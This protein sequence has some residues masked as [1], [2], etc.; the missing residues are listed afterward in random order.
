ML[1]IKPV[2]NA[3][4]ALHYYSAKD[5]YYLSDKDE[6]QQASAW[7]GKGAA[8]LSLS[9]EVLPETFL[10]LLEGKLPSGQQLGINTGEGKVRHRPGTDVTLSAPKSVS[11]LALV[12]GDRRLVEAHNAAVRETFKVIEALAAEARMTLNGETRFEK[13]KNLVVALFQHTTS[14]ELDPLLHDHGVIM[15][16]TERHDGQWRALAS[17]SKQD[18][19]QL[20]HGFREFLYQ[21]QHYLGLIYNSSLAKGVCELGFEIEIKDR[22]GNFEIKGVPEHYLK[23]TSKR[24]SQILE[25]LEEKG[26]SGAKAAEIAT[27]DTR[28]RKADID[29]AT[30]H[31]RWQEEARQCGVDF[32]A[33]IAESKVRGA[34]SITP[35]EGIAVSETAKE[36]IDAALAELS[37]F[38]TEIRHGDLVR[39][40]FMFA[41]AALHH[42]ELEEEITARFKSK[43]LLG[44]ENTAYTT[45]ALLKQEKDFVRHF[46]S[47]RGSAEAVHSEA[48]GLAGEVLSR[49]DRVQLIDVHGLTHEKTL[50]DSLVHAAEDAGLKTKVLHPGRVQT[51]RLKETLSRDTSSLWKW[52]KA[53]FKGELVQTVASFAADD[54]LKEGMVIVHDAQ[55]L[56]FE[57]L[58]RLEQ[59]LKQ[60]RS[61]LVLLNNTASTEGF[62]AGSPMNALKSAGFTLRESI[63]PLKQAVISVT[64]TL[65]THE[66]LA[67]AYSRLTGKEAEVTQIAALTSRDAA[68]ITD[69]IRTKLKGSGRLAE[70]GQAVKMLSARQLSSAQKKHLKFYEVG[71]R[72]TLNPFTREQQHYRL[73]AKEDLSLK[74][75]DCRG[76][77]QSLALDK[78]SDCLVT[79]A[80]TLELSVGDRLINHEAIRFGRAGAIA[81]GSR[82]TV[83]A[84]S[85]KGASLATAKGVFT[86]SF[87]AMKDL[88]LAYD[89]VRRPGQLN[90]SSRILLAAE[91]YQINKTVFAELSE[92]AADIHLFTPD[93]T[94]A[95]NALK[96]D[97]RRLT[98]TEVAEGVS[99]RVYRNSR[100][101][102]TVIQK[103]LT[104]LSDALA[105]PSAKES[106]VIAQTALSYATAKL[107]EREA[108]FDHKEL[109]MEAMVFAMGKTSLTDIE[110]AIAE[111]AA[112]GDL[113]HANTRWVVREAYLLEKKILSNNRE[114]QGAVQPIMAESSVSLPQALTQGQK[115]AV[116]LSL[117]TSDRFVTVQGLA[118]T[119]KTT[120]MREIKRLAEDNGFKVQGLA[121]MNTSKDELKRAGMDA[122][123]IASFLT[124]EAPYPE[125]CLFIV[126]EASMVGNEDYFNLQEKAKTL[127]AR[128]LFAGDRTQLQSPA[129]GIPHELTLETKTQDSARMDE[130]LR[131]SPNPVLKKAVVHASNREIEAS[132][133]TLATINPEKHIRRTSQENRPQESVVTVNCRTKKG[134]MDYNRIYRAI[135]EDY[136]T[137]LPEQQAET[138]VIAHAH[139]DRAA[140]NALIRDGLKA[141]GV[142]TGNEVMVKRLAARHL[143]QAEL[144]AGD[145]YKA[146]DIL[147]FNASY[148]IARR[149]DY[150]KVIA[151]DETR[152][153]LHCE[154]SQGLQ[155]S[156]N[157][158]LIAG[159]TRLSV[160]EEKKSVLAAGD[161]IRLRLT[162]KR[163]GHIANKDYTVASIAGN[164]AVLKHQEETLHLDLSKPK[165]S[166]WDY[167]YTATALGAQGSTATF[168]LALELAKRSQATTHRSHEIDITRPREQ[169]T[170]Y[171][172]DKEALIKRLATLKGDKTSAWLTY[173]AAHPSPAADEKES[174]RAHGN[175]SSP[176][177]RAEVNLR[178]KNKSPDNPLPDARAVNAALMARPDE[179][180]KAILGEP[181]AMNA[182]EM[183]YGGG[184]IVTLQGSK[185]GLWYDFNEGRGGLPLD[186]IMAS[187]QIDFKEA[188]KV[189]ADLAGLSA[190]DMPTTRIKREST[191][192]NSESIKKA[193]QLSAKSIWDGSIPIKGT[194]AEI[195]LKQYRGIERTEGLDLRF[196]PAKAKWLNYREDGLVEKKVNQIPALIIAAKNADS[197]LTGVQR[198]YLDKGTGG[199][200]RF[201]DNPKLSKGTIEGSAAILQHGTKGAAIFIAEGPETAASI[202]ASFPTATVMASLGLS[203]MKNLMPLLRTFH[204]QEVVVAADFDGDKSKTARITEEVVNE[205]RK[206]GINVR[207]VYPEP[208]KG[209]KKTDWNDVLIHKGMTAI[210]LALSGE[211]DKKGEEFDSRQTDSKALLHAFSLA[212]KQDVLL[213]KRLMEQIKKEGITIKSLDKNQHQQ[214]EK[215]V[216]KSSA[217]VNHSAI[218]NA[219][220]IKEMER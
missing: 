196:W 177:A 161:R 7:Y 140:I 102:A 197:Q 147:R 144:R 146:G 22:Y 95:F 38:S 124:H 26:L 25:R 199:K 12:G 149:G 44:R 47:T 104:A 175:V 194:L 73:V 39:T 31:Q 203:N 23:Q 94:L 98:I 33:L 113:M 85:E 84:L 187:R 214:D 179:T 178:L 5:N 182:R 70:E 71:D 109:L 151:I 81:P 15:N 69:L 188:L 141:Q 86:F 132:F 10:A 46:K 207:V 180:Y 112:Q 137:R 219:V 52:V 142:V 34:G 168:V 92:Y 76:E 119:G 32:E 185:K 189:G 170:L 171:T 184:L 183:R 202:A 59:S 205:W 162:D 150:F 60:G 129:A 54:S 152:N 40:A 80:H 78:A 156:I 55:K 62:H 167:A 181:K 41:R 126:D 11:T 87:E 61:R 93:K 186:A 100:H 191:R 116:T 135:A 27:L 131:Q 169:V 36:A 74:L 111:K 6:L 14:R 51:A 115:E 30:L 209:F 215:M 153:R 97:A 110:Q 212:N 108:A 121:P 19:S 128:L 45:A 63:T 77:T 117:T 155:F 136:L 120:M 83:S 210:Q 213:Q 145:S 75:I 17:R 90:T 88:S 154:D 166:H 122:S 200:N 164:Q 158:A 208:L 3:S 68:S 103:D 143:T 49:Y 13:T 35:F 43:A 2:S 64:E 163:R 206:N 118:G 57:E 66:G 79:K 165:D 20:E 190:G 96:N 105:S 125:K 21:N 176:P 157:P 16:M 201:M 204:H 65:A 130:I 138:L 173:E 134:A 220:K 89:Y 160:Y 4:D 1:S 99:S 107:A 148:S 211:A 174:S 28:Q 139:E 193:G 37:P 123:T 53:C 48:G 91:G 56:G 101:A 127:N 218:K 114:G 58:M 159:P 198:I 195:Y 216:V 217:Q 50:L 106:R 67:N 192:L 172:E 18:K 24:R 82:L 133:R 8:A 29:S 9:G 42:S 72:I